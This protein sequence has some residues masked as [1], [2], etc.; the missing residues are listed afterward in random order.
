L[1]L[2]IKIKLFSEV[3]SLFKVALISDCV[4]QFPHKHKC[5][6][7]CLAVA[8]VDLA[9]TYRELRLMP[10]AEALVSRALRLM[11]ETLGKDFNG[12]RMILPK[13][14][15]SARKHR[16]RQLSRSIQLVLRLAQ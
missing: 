16:L 3:L 9:V 1:H 7:M 5:F 11:E 10:E 15:L 6:G 2:H 14:P 4:A 12:V 13:N 8:M